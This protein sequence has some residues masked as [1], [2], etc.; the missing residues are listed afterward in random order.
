M[1]TTGLFTF[2]EELTVLWGAWRGRGAAESLARDVLRGQPFPEHFR[3]TKLGDDIEL[4]VAKLS[5]VKL[6]GV[7][8]E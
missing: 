8:E 4:F 2:D 6:D 1:L 5:R 3:N 7:L